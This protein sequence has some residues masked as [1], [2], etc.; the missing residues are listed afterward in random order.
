MRTLRIVGSVLV[1]ALA[2]VGSA[3]AQFGGPRQPDFRGIWNP[4][5]GS[6]AAYEMEGASG[7]NNMELTLVGKED[8]DGKTGYWLEVAMNLPQGGQAGGQM[9]AKT[10]MVF[11]GKSGSV[12]KMVIQMP[13]RG[14]MEMPAFANTQMPPPSVDIRD[15]AEKVGTEDVV[16]P[17]GTFSC[18]HYRAKDGKWEAW[19]STKVTPWGLVKSKTAET[20]MTVTKLIS[21]AQDHITGTPTKFD[22]SQ[23][24]PRGG[25]A[26]GPGAGPGGQRQ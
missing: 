10:L 25:P 15:Q 7:K 3:A 16:T 26:G 21:N 8:V 20:T 11:D 4:V 18:E 9:Y 12:S 1:L 2:L 14:P 23:F 17:A 19:L 5:I 22:P 13:G 24:M 6:G